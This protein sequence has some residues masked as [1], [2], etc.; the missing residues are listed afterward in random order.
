[1]GFTEGFLEEVM[2]KVNPDQRARVDQGKKGRKA[3]PVRST[4]ERRHRSVGSG[5]SCKLVAVPGAKG[6]PEQGPGRKQRAGL[7]GPLHAMEGAWALF[8]GG[9]FSPL[10]NSSV[11]PLLTVTVAKFLATFLEEQF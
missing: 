10:K 2:S 5:G 11:C 9:A 3:G 8:C 6:V 7:R 1:M 4:Q